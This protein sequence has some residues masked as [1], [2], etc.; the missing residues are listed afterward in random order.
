[1]KKIV[2]VSSLA[3][4]LGFGGTLGCSAASTWWQNFQSNPVAQVQSFESTVQIGLNSA[5]VAWTFLQPY[6]P[7]AQAA[8]INQTFE[9]VVATVNH[10]LTLLN[11]A[12]SAAIAAQQP[13]PNFSA[14]MQAVSD[15]FNQVLAIIA[16]YTTQ[17]TADGGAPP[18][19][20]AGK[21]GLPPAT[22]VPGL[23]DAQDASSRLHSFVK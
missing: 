13:N 9:N 23:A 6:L 1:M 3:L 11:D 2:V 19:P 20:A 5:Q 12:V 10:S 8:Q 4:A 22:S 15:A 7:P 18:A 17:P 21:M 14:L 16:Q